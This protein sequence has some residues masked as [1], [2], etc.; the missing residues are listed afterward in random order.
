MHRLGRFLVVLF[1]SFGALSLAA[2]GF[3]LWL[4]YH[5]SPRT[6]HDLPRRTV[7][8]IDLDARFRE[9][10]DG[11]PLSAL[12]GERSYALREVIDAI[13]HAGGD[14][15]VVGLFA[16]MGHA[17][18]GL[19]DVQDLRDAVGRFNASGKPSLLFAET[20]GEGGSGTLDYYLATAFGRIWL[21]PSGDVGLTGL[22]VESPFLKGTF[23]LLGIKPQFFG[24]HEYKSA[25]DMFTES[26]FTPA[27]R[28]NLGRLMDSLAEQM[29]AGIAT[30]R[31]LSPD[32]V[33]TMLGKG[34][35]LA[36]EAKAA[37]LIDEIGYRDGAWKAV[38][39][40]DKANAAEEMDIADYAAHLGSKAGTKV[41]LVT[42]SGAIHRG[43]SQRGFKSE[44]DFGAQTIAEA[45]REAIDDDSIKAILFRVDSPGGSYTASDTVW[46]E[47]RRA[48]EA[49]KPVVVSMGNVAAS[50]G[51]FVA[52]AADRIIAQPGTITGSIG[53]FTGKMV[54]D[55][56]WK[57]LGINWD[58]MHRGDNAAIW[59]ANSAFSPE[60]KARVDALLDH[61]YA[62][63]TGKAAAGRAL[64]PERMDQVARGRV[65]TGA[66]AKA[67]GLVDG[68]GGLHEAK[69]SLREV[70]GLKP[71]DPLTLIDYPRPR[72][73]WEVLAEALAG[74][75]VAERGRMA[76]LLRTAETLEPVLSRLA[77]L[78]AAPGEARLRMPP[79]DATGSRR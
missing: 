6:E 52:M 56:F 1:A 48:H 18:L 49:G 62:D 57:K 29:T 64:S 61:I 31:K 70:A 38:A 74:G 72:K 34:P 76:S 20:M 8:S 60:A 35:F 14:P 15:K 66:D 63:F 71:D 16:T 68:L 67:L 22:M 69:A 5:F 79:L 37:A 4:A 43:E 33:K 9:L 10:A 58:E 32:S 23:D 12:S 54:L 27:H 28:E 47:V 7:L 42:G 51:Y 44:P 17:R 40:Q 46:N 30:G 59:S 13:D 26:G 11:D 77:P 24:R 50:G 36:S 39:G 3:G 65:W 45:L 78:G 2:I 73:T 75:S 19:G 53:V 25:I 41:A 21:Q 55:E